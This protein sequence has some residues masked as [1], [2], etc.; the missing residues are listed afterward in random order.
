LPGVVNRPGET[1][2]N[3]SDVDNDRGALCYVPRDPLNRCQDFG[4]PTTGR[5]SL[6]SPSRA[7][8]TLGAPQSSGSI[9]DKRVLPEN[10]LDGSLNTAAGLGTPKMTQQKAGAREGIERSGG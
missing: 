4:S 6:A 3:L 1:G 2:P 7:D 5:G 8:F 9:R 10:H